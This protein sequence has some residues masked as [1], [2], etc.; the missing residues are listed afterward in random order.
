MPLWFCAGL[1]VYNSDRVFADPADAINLPHR[2][3]SSARLRPASLVLIAIAA[4]VLLI[5]PVLRRDWLTL[6]LVIG[7]GFVCLNYSRPLLGF[8]FKDVP[9]IKTFFAPTVIAAALIGL[10]WLHQG[11]PPSGAGF[12]V[13]LLRAWTLLLFNMIL[14]DLRDVA[15]DRRT[16]IVTLPVALGERR[17][18][19]LLWLLLTAIEAL[20]LTALWQAPGGHVLAWQIASF[21]VGPYLAALIVAVRT[22]RSEAFYEWAVEGVLFLPAIAALTTI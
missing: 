10:P 6:A 17:T 11:A 12:I 4:L 13:V 7:G 19:L 15:G 5:V 16:G 18:S 8:R 1:L 22:P 2:I 3:E 14:C 9:L 21:L 20:A